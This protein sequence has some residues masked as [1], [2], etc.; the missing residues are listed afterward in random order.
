[1]P[2]PI[3]GLDFALCALFVTLTLDAARTRQQVPSVLKAL[4]L[5]MPVGILGILAATTLRGI[6]Q[7]DP[8]MAG[9]ALIAVTSLR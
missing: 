2:G 7:A 8:P 9:L 1:M 5:W 4:A 3:E 6:L